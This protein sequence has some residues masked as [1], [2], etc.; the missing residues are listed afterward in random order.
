MSKRSMN[1]IEADMEAR[2][3]FDYIRIEKLF[4]I[5]DI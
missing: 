5:Y 4:L 1:D 2:N 3:A